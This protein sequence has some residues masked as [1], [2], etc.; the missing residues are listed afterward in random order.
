MFDTSSRNGQSS[1]M[2]QILPEPPAIYNNDASPQFFRQSPVD[3]RNSETSSFRNSVASVNYARK[4]IIQTRPRSF[5]AL[6]PADKRHVYDPSVEIAHSSIAEPTPRRQTT[7]NGYELTIKDLRERIQ[8]AERH[9]EGV[10]S[11]VRRY[12][13]EINKLRLIVEDL[14]HLADNLSGRLQMADTLRP[15]SSV[16]YNR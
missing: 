6:P 3:T 4:E 11:T 2:R 1:G 16:S 13:R 5:D 8:T 14:A 7:Q 9:I 10:T 12:E 15:T